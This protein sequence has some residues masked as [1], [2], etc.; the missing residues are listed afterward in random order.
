MFPSSIFVC[1]FLLYYC[2]IVISIVPLDPCL[3]SQFRTGHVTHVKK[4][5][6]STQLLIYL[7]RSSFIIELFFDSI[8]WHSVASSG[9]V[10]HFICNILPVKKPK[11][12]HCRS[13]REALN[14]NRI[15]FKAGHLRCCYCSLVS[16]SKRWK[17]TLNLGQSLICNFQ[18]IVAM[19]AA[20]VVFRLQVSSLFGRILPW[21]LISYHII[22]NSNRSLRNLLKFL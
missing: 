20:T 5:Y 11:W 19:E 15:H 22:F 9:H 21:K 18:A 10:F 3:V 6:F 8:W 12:L 13:G 16:R 4:T 17:G 14:L 1:Q 2:S 7:L